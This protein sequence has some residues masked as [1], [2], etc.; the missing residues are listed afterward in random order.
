VTSNVRVVIDTNNVVVSAALLPRSRP[1]QALNRVLEHGTLLMS[2][3][4]VAALN[5][6]LRY[7][8]S[9]SRDHWFTEWM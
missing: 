2:S 1:R 7:T 5:A 3:A 8:V 4:T 6:V 9:F